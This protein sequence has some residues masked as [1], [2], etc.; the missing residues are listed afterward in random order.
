M[1]AMVRRLFVLAVPVLLLACTTLGSA[2]PTAGI[3]TSTVGPVLPTPTVPPPPTVP[4]EPTSIPGWPTYHN[5]MIGYAFDYPPEAVLRTS[6]VTGYPSEELPAGLEPGQYFATLEAT[7]T[8]ALCAGI[9]LPAAS[10]VLWAPEDEGGR[11]GGPCGVTGIGVFDIRT[12]RSPITIDGEALSLKTTRLYEVG[13]DTLADEFG[14]V[15]LSDGTRLSFMSHWQEAGLTYEDYLA[16]RAII[17]QVMSS[18]R[19]DP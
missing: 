15:Q 8:E 18:Y 7:Y 1:T 19:S 17:L 4:P 2:A 10:F 13:T 12:E 11:Y 3:S 6:G 9:E 16:D 14:T 5:A